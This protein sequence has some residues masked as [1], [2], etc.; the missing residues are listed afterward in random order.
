MTEYEANMK[1]IESVTIVVL[2]KM[3]ARLSNFNLTKYGKDNGMKGLLKLN[4]KLDDI[5]NILGCIL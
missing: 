4:E 1:G 3:Q 5:Y 2:N